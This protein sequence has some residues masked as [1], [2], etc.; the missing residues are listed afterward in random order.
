MNALSPHAVL[1]RAPELVVEIDSSDNVK[2][3]H[4][5]RGYLFGHDALGL[6]DVFSGG[7]TVGEALARMAPRLQG[8]RAVE[9]A[10]A[11]VA[12]MYRAG[13]LAEDGHV[14][15]SE[16]S[17]PR[18]GYDASY[19]QIRMLQDTARKRAF[20]DAIRE[21]VRPDDVVLD[22]GTGSG[23]LAVAAAQAGARQVY[24]V[25]PT[26]VIRIAELVARDNG[27]ADRITDHL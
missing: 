5:G 12:Q 17:F 26:N 2:V 15:F 16:L 27:V 19:V 13:V 24:A 3:H 1:H 14:G 11:C 6:L 10:L 4:D 20:L 23:I 7:C 9:D 22:L 18:G 8:R 21:V 25:E